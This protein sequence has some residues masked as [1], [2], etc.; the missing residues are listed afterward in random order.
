MTTTADAYIDRVLDF[1]PPGT[2]ERSQIATELRGHI[3]ERLADGQP[4]DEVL[5]QLGDP[6]ALAESYLAA[7]PLHSASFAR[8]AVAKL[9]DIG[10]ILMVIFPVIGLSFFVGPDYLR[11]FVLLFGILATSMAAVAYL[12]V[13]EWRQGQ[14]LGKRLM[15][16]RVVRESGARISLGQAI[17]RQ[18]PMFLQ[19]Y[20]IDVLFALFTDKSQRAFEL[21]SKTRVVD[22][23]DAA[24]ARTFSGVGQHAANGGV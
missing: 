3:A 16:L 7:V 22:A 15:G 2:P 24:G 8:R 20:W 5:R 11:P 1:L 23:R 9:V 4:L 6:L 14:T 13:A 12:V 10:L 18:I 17:V 21:L 19:M